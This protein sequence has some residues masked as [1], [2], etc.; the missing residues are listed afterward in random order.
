[1]DVNQVAQLISNVGFP[2]AVAIGLFWY[3]VKEQGKLREVIQA[4]TE[5]IKMI[6]EHFRKEDSD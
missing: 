3:I 4:N 1:M 5:T 6:L 2:M